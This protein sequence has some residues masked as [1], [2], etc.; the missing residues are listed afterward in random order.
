[1]P[2]K[3]LSESEYLNA[4]AKELGMS[5]SEAKKVQEAQEKVMTQQLRQRGAVKVP[6]LGTIVAKKKPAQKGGKLVRNP[7]TG[8]K[9]KSKAKPASFKVRLKP[10]KSFKDRL[11]GR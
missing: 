6:L 10:K 4:F 7:F 8:Q 5:R 3:P 1:M 11:M 9:V 2:G